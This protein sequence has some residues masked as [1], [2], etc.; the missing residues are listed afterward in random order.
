MTSAIDL[1]NARL[2][3]AKRALRNIPHHINCPQIGTQVN[4]GEPDSCWQGN[5]DEGCCMH[6]YQWRRIHVLEQKLHRLRK[7]K[8]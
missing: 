8:R 4:R 7:A 5:D 2:D 1:T 3:E 6:I